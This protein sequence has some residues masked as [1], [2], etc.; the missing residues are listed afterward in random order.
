MEDKKQV[1]VSFMALDPYMERNIPSPKEQEIVGRNMVQW[2]DRNL[3]PEFLWELYNS[4]P[5]LRAIINGTTDFIVGDTQNLS[6]KLGTFDT[7]VVNKKRGTVRDLLEA[8][9]I[10][11]ETFGGFA[12]QVIRSV[13][14]GVVELYH[15][16]MRYLRM[17]KEGDVFYYSEKWSHRGKHKVTVYP[18]FMSIDKERWAQLTPE[19]KERNYTSILLVKN[20]ITQVY[21]SPVYAAA[22]DDCETERR[23]SQFHLNSINNG[24]TSSMIVN[25]NAGV[26]SDEMKA[27]IERSFTEKFTG[28]QNAG[29]VMFSWNPDRTNATTITEPKVENF[30]DRY[31]ALSKHIRQQIFTAFRANP[32]LFGI[33][34]ENLGFSDEEYQSAFRLYNRTMVRPV[35]RK[36]C[37]AFDKIFGTL[38]V[39]TI[40]PFSLEESAE[41]RVS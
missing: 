4:V 5:S 29:R 15:C 31:L 6:V 2:G 19:E 18:A 22:V 8:T 35:Q 9:S 25:F 20:T 1:S 21:P 26:P 3:Y 13:T 34:T 16:P 32:N 28:A 7:N 40:T 14:G 38:G 27:E 33:P 41:T 23:V 24:F 37:D 30:G 39:L 11:Y 10:D 36:I 12:I 17:N